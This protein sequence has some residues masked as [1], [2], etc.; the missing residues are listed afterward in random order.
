[1]ITAV[2]VFSS[3]ILGCYFFD[4]VFFFQAEDGIRDATVTGVQT[5]ALP[6]SP[7][8][9]SSDP[10]EGGADFGRV[11]RDRQTDNVTVERCRAIQIAYGQVRLEEAAHGYRIDHE[12]GAGTSAADV[13]G[14]WAK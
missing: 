11:E 13:V 14:R 3:A 10:E 5:C 12:S 2:G 6:I 1:M 4:L 7:P 8:S 9:S